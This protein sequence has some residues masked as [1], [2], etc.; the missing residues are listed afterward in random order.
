MG[1]HNQF[2]NDLNQGLYNGYKLDGGLVNNT[3]IKPLLD[4]NLDKIIVIAT[5]HDYIL[6]DEIKNSNNVDNII[7]VRPKTI[8]D[9]ND[10][11]KFEMEFCKNIYHE[12]Y[13][14]GKN[15]NISM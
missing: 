2:I 12:G 1:L 7:I 6:P 11:L 8:F 5:N 9:K 14:I 15:L 4:K 3:L 10:T 13:E